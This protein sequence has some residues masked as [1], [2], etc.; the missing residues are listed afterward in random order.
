M[1]ISP[2]WTNKSTGHQIMSEVLGKYVYFAQNNPSRYIFRNGGSITVCGQTN[3]QATTVVFLWGNGH[4]GEYI[5][6]AV[7]WY[8]R[9]LKGAFIMRAIS[10]FSAWRIVKK[11]RKELW[12]DQRNGNSHLISLSLCSPRDPFLCFIG[13]TKH[14]NQAFFPS[15]IRA[16]IKGGEQC[17][18]KQ[19]L[20]STY[21]LFIS[22]Y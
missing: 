9:L 12:N 19:L 5:A 7:D 22:F 21:F 1:V 20:F 3:Q 13:A 18:E 15:S 10:S 8:T 6:A 11:K 17:W 16:W 14:T 2:Q 4:M